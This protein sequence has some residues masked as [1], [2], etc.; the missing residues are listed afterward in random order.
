MNILMLKIQIRKEVPK[1][2]AEELHFILCI[3]QP[4]EFDFY[5]RL[6]SFDYEKE[7]LLSRLYDR[8]ILEHE[9]EVV[10]GQ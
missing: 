5:G 2:R 10:D 8:G 6:Y 3:A 7:N 4:L 1:E 9:I